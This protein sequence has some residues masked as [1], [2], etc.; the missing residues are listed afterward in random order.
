MKFLRFCKLFIFSLNL[1]ILAG[2]YGSTYTPIARKGTASSNANTIAVELRNCMLK[3]A[4]PKD[5]GPILRKEIES[6]DPRAKIASQKILL[7]DHL[8]RNGHYTDYYAIWDR[9]QNRSLPHSVYAINPSKTQADCTAD[10]F[11]G[12]VSNI[13]DLLFSGRV[14]FSI[15]QL[16][17]NGNQA[18]RNQANG[19]VLYANLNGHNITNLDSPS[20]VCTFSNTTTTTTTTT[21]EKINSDYLR[22]VI[23]IVHGVGGAP[24]NDSFKGITPELSLQVVIIT[25]FHENPK[26]RAL[27]DSIL[28]NGV[29][30]QDCPQGKSVGSLPMIAG[31][32]DNRMPPVLQPTDLVSSK[33][34]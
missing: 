16:Q 34:N 11:D 17:T 3:V 8:R 28:P 13:L 9:R 32:P 26:S 4:N 15:G 24:V 20:G 10:V 18:N 14:S 33:A 29:D 22:V 2:L 1:R 21:T 12:I 25:M 19:F 31:T 5:V 23:Q 27:A 7:S 6:N 30:A